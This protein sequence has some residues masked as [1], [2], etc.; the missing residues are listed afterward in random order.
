MGDYL[1]TPIKDKEI[2]EGENS[3]LRFGACG[4]QG[5]RKNMEDAHMYDLSIGPDVSLF[6]VF[7]GHGGQEVAL[8]SKKHMPNILKSNKSFKEGNYPKALSESF[9]QIDENLRTPE[10][11]LELSNISTQISKAPAIFAKPDAEEL[12]NGVGCTACVALITK[13]EIYVANAGDSRSVLCRNKKAVAMSEDHKP[14]LD[15]E[16]KRIE[17]AGGHVTD[18]RVNGVLNLSRSLGDFDYKPDKKKKPE[19]QMITAYPE[20][21]IEKITPDTE[22]LI[23]GCDG[24]WDCLTNEKAVAVIREK[25]NAPMP[26]KTAKV[27]LGK[28]IGEVLDSILAVDIGNPE[29]IGCDNMT[30]IVVQFTK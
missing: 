12:A 9:L 7:D 27:K 14:E 24:I 22:F 21:R 8:Y 6:G 28:I 10:G 11:K 29:G 4:M 5:W 23:I 25:L 13:T 16:R 18:G 19:D 1:S 2:V 15:K 20:I 17:S 30:C 26:D 3:R